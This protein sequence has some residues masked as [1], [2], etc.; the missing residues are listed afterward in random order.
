MIWTS[1]LD[2][3]GLHRCHMTT[4]T[5]NRM[6]YL[7]RAG[8]LA[9][10]D[11]TA[12]LLAYSRV[13]MY[14]HYKGADHRPCHLDLVAS[15]TGVVA[16]VVAVHAIEVDEDVDEVGEEII[17]VVVVFNDRGAGQ[18]IVGQ[19]SPVLYHLLPQQLRE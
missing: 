6:V 18:K 19:I 16:E 3:R 1:V 5:R 14:G 11:K 7:R 10:E 13:T 4:R 9:Q 17:M 15:A 8:L 2:L 12:L